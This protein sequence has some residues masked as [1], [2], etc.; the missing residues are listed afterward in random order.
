[1]PSLSHSRRLENHA[2]KVSWGFFRV[3]YGLGSSF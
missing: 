1:L 3:K 2:Y